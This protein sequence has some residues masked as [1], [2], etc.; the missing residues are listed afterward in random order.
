[1]NSEDIQRAARDLH[2]AAERANRAA[3][4]IEEVTQQL[5]VL[6]EDGYGGN[7][8]RLIELLEALPCPPSPPAVTPLEPWTWE[9]AKEFCL[10]KEIQFPVEAAHRA[11]EECVR[12]QKEKCQ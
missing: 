12:Q 8:L 5:R 7:A 6:F 3:D 4:R 11:V 1:M 10:R 9:Q 2:A